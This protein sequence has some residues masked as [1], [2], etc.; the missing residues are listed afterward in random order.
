MGQNED[1]ELVPLQADF[2]TVWYGYRRSQVQYYL[3]QTE[4]EMRMLTEDRDSALS[5]KGELS[6]QLD[7]AR[8]ENESLRQQFDELCRTP[9]D[10]KTLS[11]RLQRMVQL[12]QAEA[13]EIVSSAHATAEHEW[14]R[15]EQAASDLRARYERWVAEADEWRKQWERERKEQLEAT[16]QEVERMAREAEQHR[17]RLDAEAEQRRE[18]VEEDF[19][20]HM[21]AQRE[22]AKRLIAERDQRSRDEAER[23]IREATEEA[24]RRMQHADKHVETMRRVR[25]QLGEQVRS[26]QEALS[27][28]E[29]FLAASVSAEDSEN[30]DAYVAE[31]V[32]N[33]QPAELDTYRDELSGNQPEVEVPEQRAA[34]LEQPADVEKAADKP[35]GV[36]AETEEA[37]SPVQSS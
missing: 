4:A 16:R 18:Q 11:G 31:N 7:Q 3:Q 33:I 29:P 15:A 9:I 27:I 14:A 17:R 13:D 2:D 12:A 34:E 22:E 37:D 20:I 19:E 28:A 24:A 6:S 10:P 30:A 35:A 36:S 21:A 5:Q 32:H 25:Q 1:R 23:R 26:A 8:A